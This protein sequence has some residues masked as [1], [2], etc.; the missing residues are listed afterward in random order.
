MTLPRFT[1]IALFFLLPH[2]HPASPG[3]HDPSP[4]PTAPPPPPGENQH[5]FPFE[6]ISPHPPEHVTGTADLCVHIFQVLPLLLFIDIYFY[7]IITAS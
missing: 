5:I 6:L 4:P 1:H 7:Q 3:L 2:A